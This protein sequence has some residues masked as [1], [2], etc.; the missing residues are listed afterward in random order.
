MGV[1]TKRRQQWRWLGVHD[2]GNGEGGTVLLMDNDDNDKANKPSPQVGTDADGGVQRQPDDCL[3]SA[4]WELA[5]SDAN[6]R[7]GRMR[8]SNDVTNKEG[9]RG[10][11][12]TTIN[13]KVIAIVTSIAAETAEAANND[14]GDQQCG[15]Q[16]G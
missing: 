13:Q 15:L 2:K 6:A 4:W 14:M 7:N 11:P 5:P 8:S 12:H 1:T 10:F 9:G 3:A 16:Q